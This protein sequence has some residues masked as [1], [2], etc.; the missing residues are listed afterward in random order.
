[1]WLR[2]SAVKVTLVGVT[3]ACWSSSFLGE[4]AAAH[5]ASMAAPASADL[6]RIL[7]PLQIGAMPPA[8]AQGLKQ[9]R[10]IGVAILLG[11]DGGDARLLIGLF[12]AQ[13]CKIIGV[14]VLSPTLCQGQGRFGGGFGIG[15]GLEAFGVLRQRRQSIGDILEGVEDGAAILLG[16]LGIGGAGG[17]FLMQKRARI[18]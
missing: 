12:G 11:L 3:E 2:C 5:S 6:L 1:M 10:R 18:E 9:R 14:A 4:Q 16:R 8:A 7:V 17:A 13:Q 15:R